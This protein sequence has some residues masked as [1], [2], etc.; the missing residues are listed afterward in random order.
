M[1]ALV[2]D[3]LPWLAAF[4]VLDAVVHLRRG[5]V[6]FARE[7]FGSVRP[8]R[9]GLRLA[10]LSPLG[11]SVVGYELPLIATPGGVW[12]EDPEVGAPP[13][14][15]EET[16]EFLSFEELG[17]VEGL[18]LAVRAAGERAHP[19]DDLRGPLALVSDGREGP[20]QNLVLGAA[21]LHQAHAAIR[22]VHDRREGLVHLVGD[23]RGHLR[24]GREPA[25][26]GKGV[27]VIDLAHL[28]REGAPQVA[29]EQVESRELATALDEERVHGQL[30]VL[31]ASERGVA[32]P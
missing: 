2:L 20:D 3:I 23:A 28:D 13:V 10:G 1:S 14:V 29:E 6:V 4:F 12:W 30:G 19:S 17:E 11:L 18:T 16:L 21:L 22:V 26:L 9:G 8:V 24:E 31:L 7:M 32:S 15:R 27:L 25:N 5:Q